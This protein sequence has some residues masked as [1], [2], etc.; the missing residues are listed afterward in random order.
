M[1]KKKWDEIGVLNQEEALRWQEDSERWHP[2]NEDFKYSVVREPEWTG[3]T[4]GNGISNRAEFWLRLKQ[5][6]SRDNYLDA[7]RNELGLTYG[8]KIDTGNKTPFTPMQV[9]SYAIKKG[10]VEKEKH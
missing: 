3:N 10:W 5:H 8:V 2:K 6:N 7:I 1:W 9:L 4:L